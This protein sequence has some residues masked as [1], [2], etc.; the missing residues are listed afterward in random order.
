MQNEGN[1]TTQVKQEVQ[2]VLDPSFRY[3]LDLLCSLCTAYK[4]VMVM[5]W[6]DKV[7]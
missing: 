1:V 5:L 7:K 2:I 6:R 3:R 4:I